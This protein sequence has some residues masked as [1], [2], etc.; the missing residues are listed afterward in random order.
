MVN[1]RRCRCGASGCLEAYV[2]GRAIV[3]RYDELRRRPLVDPG[4]DL[5]ERVDAISGANARDR[6]AAK[7]VDETAMYLG[8]GIA[9]L[10]N[11]FNPERIVIGGWVTQSLGDRL[12]P[13]VRE[14]AAE[15]A[16]HMPYNDVSIVPAEL[17]RDA[18]AL[19]AATLP[20]SQFLESGAIRAVKA[21]RPSRAMARGARRI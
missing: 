18:V 3:A 1:G 21:T 12:L 19:G 10:I 20:V 6:S 5:A 15:H 2:G 14:V 4:S 11:L 17:G 13:R 16:L 8:V 7:V 9:D